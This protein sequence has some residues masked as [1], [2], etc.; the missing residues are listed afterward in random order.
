MQRLRRLLAEEPRAQV[1]EEEAGYLRAAFTVPP[2]GFTDDVEF[3]WSE[4]EGVVHFRSA[5]RI[6]SWDLGVN[7]RRMRRLARRWRRMR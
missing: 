2:L 1:V 7:R 6:G 4:E 3:L 5:S